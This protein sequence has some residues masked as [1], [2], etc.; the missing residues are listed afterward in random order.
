MTV[1][2]ARDFFD[3][4]VL[5]LLPSL[6]LLFCLFYFGYLLVV[7]GNNDTSAIT[8]S[9]FVF[10]ATLSA[11]CFSWSGSEFLTKNLKL[12]ITMAGV[13]FLTSSMLFLVITIFKYAQL[14]FESS[15]VNVFVI[16]IFQVL[17]G[18]SFIVAVVTTRWGT[19]RLV[20]SIVT[21]GKENE[22]LEN[23]NK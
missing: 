21:Y 7:K 5:D 3:A 19:N 22:R 2:K 4:L 14:Q 13:R 16:Y 11:L 23:K 17:V 1:K 8:I 20:S 6:S 10:S 12:N 15:S 18:S 9:A